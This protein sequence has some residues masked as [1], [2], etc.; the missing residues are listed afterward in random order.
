MHFSFRNH[1]F[2]ELYKS[3]VLHFHG[4]IDGAMPKNHVFIVT[5]WVYKAI[6]QGSAQNHCWNNYNKTSTNG[7][8]PALMY[9]Y[10]A[11][12]SIKLTKNYKHSFDGCMM[13]IILIDTN[14][15]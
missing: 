5:I 6:E 12:F 9:H 10:T 2:L 1:G 13:L 3:Y 15:I 14:F 8:Q 4:L 7:S 11:N